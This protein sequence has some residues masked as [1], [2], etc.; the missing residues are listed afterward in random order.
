MG[1]AEDVRFMRAA[2]KLARK[3]VGFTSPNPAVGAV[4]VRNNKIIAGGYHRRAGL[5]HAEIEA[6]SGLKARALKGSTLYVTLEPCCC[7]GRTPP[8]TDAVIGSG[9]SKVVVGA[10]DPN[11]A[12]AGE[13]LRAL[14]SA[15]LTV[16]S[17]VLESESLAINEGYA[18]HI[19]TG[20]PFV[21][22]KLASSLD[23]RTA[24]SRGESRWITGEASRRYVHRVR[25]DVDAVMVG[26]G[27][28]LK[29]D[30]A[31]TVRL[32]G[33]KAKNPVRVIVDSSFKTP[34]G[35]KVFKGIEGSGLYIFTTKKAGV[36]KIKKAS[37]LGARVVTLRE[38]ARGVS[39]K[40]VVKRLGRDNITSLLIEGGG[41]LAASA[42][43]EGVVD[44]VM[45]FA[46]PL[47]LGADAK[48][49]VSD[50]S[51][52]ALK[53]APRLSKV[54]ARRMGDDLLV[55]GYLSGRKRK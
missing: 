9:I 26:S 22:L 42:I 10:T 35:A 25:S 3:G 19:T 51:V 49:A 34:L 40:S 17:G 27:T 15:G 50:L 29:D 38:T 2:L 54:K 46:A 5:A 14:K 13:G 12:V 43:K 7:Y 41:R 11:P 1:A 30:P 37:A 18:R 36:E 52:S 16:V 55:E 45:W 33:G 48:P 28:I 6:L 21:I 20:L 47:I 53:L 31:L 8:C 23:G 24:T 4:I 32:T 44:K 39:L